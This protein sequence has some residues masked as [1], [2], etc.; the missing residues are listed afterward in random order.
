[1]PFHQNF[2]FMEPFRNNF[3]QV[4]PT[5][6]NQ[7]LG[8]ENSILLR[9]FILLFNINIQVFN[10]LIQS[11][12]A[13]AYFYYPILSTLSPNMSCSRNVCVCVLLYYVQEEAE[14]EDQQRRRAVLY[15]IVMES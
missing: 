1:M 6:K 9:I 3:L 4:R 14:K 8:I 5:T 10:K 11:S 12:M 13:T 2:I 7:S 15:F